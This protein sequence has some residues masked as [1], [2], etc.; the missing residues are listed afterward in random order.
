MKAVTETGYEQLLNSGL[1]AD[2]IVKEALLNATSV[3]EMETK[4]IVSKENMNQ[5]LSSLY[6][7]SLLNNLSSYMSSLATRGKTGAIQ[8]QSGMKKT[9]DQNK[10]YMDALIKMGE[11]QKE[12]NDKAVKYAKEEE[13][14]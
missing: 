11:K 12:L 1:D 9:T 5:Y 3:A 2:A 10:A 13:L 4:S 14:L 6:D 8:I 7:T